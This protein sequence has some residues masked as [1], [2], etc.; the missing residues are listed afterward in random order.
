MKINLFKC[1]NLL[2]MSLNLS[3]GKFVF[4]SIKFKDKKETISFLLSVLSQKDNIMNYE[5]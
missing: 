4:Y 1:L 2:E 3:M 5:H